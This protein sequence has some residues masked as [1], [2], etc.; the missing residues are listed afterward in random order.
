MIQL[1]FLVT[2]LAFF[3]SSQTPST[4]DW[5]GLSPLKSTRLDV[6]R[7]LGSPDSKGDNQ[8]TYYLSDVT[9]V[10]FFS[11]N[12]KCENKLP[13]TSWNVTSDTVTA[14]DV[15]FRHPPLVAEARFDLAKFKKIKGP[16][17][18][19]GRYYYLNADGSFAIEGD[20]NHIAGYHY[21]PGSKQNHLR[22]E[23]SKHH[24]DS[25]NPNR[26]PGGN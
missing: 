21:R 19:I 11:T 10:L 8:M 9:V 26:L 4:T 20:D 1:I 22:C 16:S 17:D 24:Y 15:S 2:G 5:R 12:P 14:I 18:M 13:Y 7:T 6:E 25:Q 23:P 3:G